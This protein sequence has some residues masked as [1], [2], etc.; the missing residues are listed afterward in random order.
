MRTKLPT[1]QRERPSPTNGSGRT[2]SPAPP[3]GSPPS[4]SCIPSTLSELGSKVFLIIIIIIIYNSLPAHINGDSRFVPCSVFE[5]FFDFAVNDGRVSH[6][7]SYKNTAHAVFTIAR[8]EVCLFIPPTPAILSIKDNNC[9]HFLYLVK[10]H[11]F[12]QCND[13][14]ALISRLFRFMAT[15]CHNI[16]FKIYWNLM[17]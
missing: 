5:G 10:L 4:R 9:Q 14:S 2:P 17:N 6:V 15:G 1:C 7:P 13:Q 8:S 16:A 3:L 11:N 12:L